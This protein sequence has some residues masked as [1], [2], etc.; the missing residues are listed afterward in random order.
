[1]QKEIQ[2][3]VATNV[4]CDSYLKVYK[5]LLCEEDY[6]E[7]SSDAKLLFCLI[8]NKQAVDHKTKKDYVDEDGKFYIVYKR[9]NMVADIKRSKNKVVK[10]KEELKEAG[11]IEE[12]QVKGNKPNHLYVLP[13]NIENVTSTYKKGNTVK[14]AFA[15][16]PKFLLS[17]DYY[18]NLSNTSILLYT[19]LRDRFSLSL[20][21]SNYS[22][23]YVDN[24]NKVYCVFNNEKLSTIL[25]IS[26]P[27]LIKYKNE[28]IAIGLL[29]QESLGVNKTNRLYLYEPQSLPEVN[30]IDTKSVVK[31]KYVIT[32]R[33]NKYFT[34]GLFYKSQGSQNLV[35]KGHELKSSNTSTSN[36]INNNTSTNDMYDMYKESSESNTYQSNHN[37]QDANVIPFDNSYKEVLVSKLPMQLGNFLKNFSYNELQEVKSIILKGKSNF[38]NQFSLNISLEDVE[39]NLVNMLKRVH[40]KSVKQQESIQSLAPFIMTSVYNVFKQH[41]EEIEDA[42]E[43]QFDSEE[44][45]QNFKQHLQ[46]LFNNKE[47]E[48]APVR[49]SKEMTP[50]WLDNPDYVDSETNQEEDPYIYEERIAFLKHLEER[51]G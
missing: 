45:K 49:K 9:N 27:T 39:P 19:V 2:N 47:K 8:A 28:L 42:V 18:R 7:V 36:T 15:K 37:N 22:K 34:K 46:N 5:F 30:S 20:E 51:W 16:L 3:K 33:S 26:E 1:M 44:S 24:T 35:S 10:L 23:S 6:K 21:K 29:R 13:P 32:S 25:N 40:I 31:S 43:V 11:L 4:N 14:L 12:V 50:E 48:A 38:N 41:H 17:H